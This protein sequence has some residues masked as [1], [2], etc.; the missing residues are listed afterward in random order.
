VKISAPVAVTPMECS[1][2][3]DRLLSRVTAVQ[4]SASTFV[5][6]RPRFTIGSMVKNMPSSS[7]G[8]VPG[9]P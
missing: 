2:C 6:G 5:S 4:S 3:A 8:P 7:T 1:N 9:R